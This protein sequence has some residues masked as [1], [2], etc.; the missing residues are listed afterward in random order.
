MATYDLI[1]VVTKQLE[2]ECLERVNNNSEGSDDDRWKT[3][4]VFLLAF[5]LVK[6]LIVKM[7]GDGKLC[8]D[9]RAF[10]ENVVLADLNDPSE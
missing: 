9:I 2:A 4:E 10:L 1:T 5:C 3:R 8:F 7:E 6:N